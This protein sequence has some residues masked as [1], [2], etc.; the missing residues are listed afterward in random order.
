MQM[1]LC[2]IWTEPDFMGWNWRWNLP[3]ETV[4]VSWYLFLI[5]HVKLRNGLKRMTIICTFLL[6]NILKKIINFVEIWSWIWLKHMNNRGNVLSSN[7]S[8]WQ[9]ISIIYSDLLNGE[10]NQAKNFVDFSYGIFFHSKWYCFFTEWKCN[11]LITL[12]VFWNAS[13]RFIWQLLCPI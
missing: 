10:F 5:S 8:W 7:L 1:T 11:S 2:I 12:I 3:E 9:L 13:N 6:L 4:K